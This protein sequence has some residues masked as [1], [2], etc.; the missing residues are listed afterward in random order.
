MPPTLNESTAKG[1]KAPA[2]KYL[3]FALQKESYGIGVLHVREII[4]VVEITALPEMPDYIRGVINLRG[5]I[6][7]VLDLRVRFGLAAA[8]H[9][10]QTCIV[11]VLTKTAEGRATQTGL[12]VDRVE[13][14][15]N[16]AAS[17]IEEAPDFGADGSSESVVGIATVKGAIKTLLDI[18]RVLAAGGHEAVSTSSAP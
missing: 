6:I 3:T 17:E 15:I 5:K 13:E 4:R 2:G 18:E 11:V 12:I 10:E 8:Q 1:A 14:V 7:P 16:V 9:T